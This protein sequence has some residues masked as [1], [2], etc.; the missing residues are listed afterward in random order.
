MDPVG[1]GHLTGS[2]F[3]LKYVEI[4][5]CII[6]NTYIIISLEKNLHGS[7]ILLNGS[8]DI[9]L[10]PDMF[11]ARIGPRFLVSGSSLPGGIDPD[12]FFSSD[13]DPVSINPEPQLCQK[14]TNDSR[15]QPDIRVRQGASYSN[16]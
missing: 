3:S 10:D 9:M 15:F 14:H 1:S 5:Q 13:P 6:Y 4:E 11:W 16:A 7:S 12:P 8:N 2:L